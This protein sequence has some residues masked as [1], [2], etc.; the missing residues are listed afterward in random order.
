MR[1]F[2]TIVLP[3]ILGLVPAVKEANENRAGVRD[4]VMHCICAFVSCSVQRVGGAY[5][6]L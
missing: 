6:V 4:T 3:K 1:F 5:F 2:N